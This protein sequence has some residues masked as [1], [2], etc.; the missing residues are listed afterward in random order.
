[1]GKLMV[2]VTRCLSLCTVLLVLPAVAAAQGVTLQPNQGPLGTGVTATGT[3]W[4]PGTGVLIY[5]E[6]TRA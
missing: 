4:A 5:S 6:V 3:G 2:G 1:V